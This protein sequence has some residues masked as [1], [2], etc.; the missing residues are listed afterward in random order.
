MKN[1][2]LMR[3][4]KSSWQYNIGDQD[5]PLLE[6]GINDGYLVGR[7]L[8]INQIEIDFAFSSP[9]NRALHTAMI[10]LKELKFPMKNFEVS[11]DIYDFSGNQVLNF[12]KTRSNNMDTILIFG[13][14]H[15]FTHLANSLGDKHIDNVPTSGFVHIRFKENSWGKISQGATIQTIFPKQ[16]RG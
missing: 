5:R 14:N 15:A 12:I 6:R 3:H 2:F 9:A 10:C 8:A 11:S 4:G 13:H 7:E 1:L 16:L